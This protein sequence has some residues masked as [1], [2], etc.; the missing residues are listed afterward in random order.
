MRS[1]WNSR[2]L[3]WEL[4]RHHLL[5]LAGHRSPSPD[6]L[7]LG[8]YQQER[9]TRSGPRCFLI[10]RDKHS[11]TGELGKGIVLNSCCGIVCS[12]EKGSRLWVTLKGMMPSK[13]S[14]ILKHTPCD[15]AYL[16]LK[17]R[18]HEPVLSADRI[19]VPNTREPAREMEGCC[20]QI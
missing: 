8:I 15:S 19:L 7:P 17:N 3:L 2:S 11:S 4:K 12:K 18:G 9:E 20:V 16:R 10:A 6:T 14:Q 13:S 5:G 1:K